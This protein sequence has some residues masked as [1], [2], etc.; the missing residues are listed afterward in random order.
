MYVRIF[1]FRCGS[2][3]KLQYCTWASTQQ[4]LISN[5]I[6]TRHIDLEHA[7]PAAS[8]NKASPQTAHLHHT[9]FSLTS[10]AHFSSCTCSVFT[11]LR[12]RGIHSTSYKVLTRL[13]HKRSSLAIYKTCSL[14]HHALTSM[15]MH[16]RGPLF[17]SWIVLSIG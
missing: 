2:A 1:F 9:L 17:E 5:R 16:I 15:I 14:F 13:Y 8:T 7:Q 12:T 11:H 6:R 10:H 3:I 4:Y